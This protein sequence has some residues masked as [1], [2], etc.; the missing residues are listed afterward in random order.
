[1]ADSSGTFIA[2]EPGS[3]ILS[4]MEELERLE[5]FGSIWVERWLKAPWVRYADNRV[6]TLATSKDMIVRQIPHL[7]A[8]HKVEIV[9]DAGAEK[10]AAD[11][12]Q[13]KRMVGQ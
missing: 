11:Y 8:K 1:M 6:F 12:V 10:R 3:A 2:P 9:A 4:L 7:L 5:A 13:A